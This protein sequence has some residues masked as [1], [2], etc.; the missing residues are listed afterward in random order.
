MHIV[1]YGILSS[2]I[3]YALLKTTRNQGWKLYGLIAIL[4][5]GYGMSDELHQH[6]VPGRSGQ[7]IDLVANLMGTGLMCACHNLARR[8]RAMI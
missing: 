8:L 4:V 1:E 2:L 6:F 5:L 7:L 3:L